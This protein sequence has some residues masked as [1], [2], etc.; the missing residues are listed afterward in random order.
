VPAAEYWNHRGAGLLWFA[1]LAAPAAWAIDQF[2]SYVVVR[3]LCATG[4]S[5][6]LVLVAIAGGSLGLAIAGL[7]VGWW[8]LTRL[9]EAKSDGSRAIDRSRFMA[10][11]AV[12]FNG[13]IAVLIVT[14]AAL[15]FI[16]TPCE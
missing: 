16:L 8:C 6:V 15:P 13:L 3:P 1:V 7:G 9:H 14:A 11:V 5:D 2:L 12:G 10:L 4:I